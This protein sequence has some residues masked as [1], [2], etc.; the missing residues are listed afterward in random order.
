MAT[1]TLPF[2]QKTGS[3]ALTMLMLV[4]TV[5]AIGCVAY[6]LGRHHHGHRK[7]RKLGINRRHD[8]RHGNH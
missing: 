2:L 1:M 7:A 6:L 3:P 4:L 5:A 8:G